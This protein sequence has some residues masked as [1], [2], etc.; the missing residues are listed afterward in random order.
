MV[1]KS[2]QIVHVN[3]SLYLKTDTDISLLV[4]SEI[5]T[6]AAI[7]N[8]NSYQSVIRLCCGWSKCLHEPLISAPE[9]SLFCFMVK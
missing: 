7:N 2:C 9:I 5:F 4:Y 1:L 3:G 8:V 6:L